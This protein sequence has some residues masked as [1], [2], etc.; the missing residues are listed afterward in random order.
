[1]AGRLVQPAAIRKGDQ[2][3]VV[4]CEQVWSEISNYLEGDVDATLR[5]AMDDHFGTCK[6]CKSVLEGTRNVV[7]LYGDERMIDVPAG[8]GRRLER[9]LAQESRTQR[10]GWRMW[11][12]WLVPVAGILL[13][14]GGLRVAN[15]VSIPHPMRSEHAQP[16][17]NIPP[18]L[19]VVVS[20]D[21]KEFHVPGCKFIHNKDKE[22]TLTAKQ[23]MEQ[24]YVPCVRCLRKYLET[25]SAGRTS[26]E[27]EANLYFDADGERVHVK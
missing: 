8:F 7:H 9:R 15:S 13:I 27:L 3:M 10:S 26:L 6:R 22:R 4:N 20:A 11:S 14:T 2:A 21:A 23:A 12:A 1:V 19:T 24:G 5:S 25:A 17:R 18:D 16:A